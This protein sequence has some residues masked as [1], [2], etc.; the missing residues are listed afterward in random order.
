[1]RTKTRKAFLSF[2]FCFLCAST[3]IAE[4]GSR[5]WLRYAPLERVGYRFERVVADETS[6]TLGVALRELHTAWKSFTGGEISF[7][8]VTDANTALVVGTGKSK[9]VNALLPRKALNGLGRDGFLITS[10]GSH[11]VIA[12]EGDQG[13]LYG[14]FHFLRLIASGLWT[15]ET[16]RETPAYERRLLNHW[17]NLDGSIERGYAGGSLW[18]WSQLP[19]TLS[20]RYEAYA[21]AN[22]S[23]G[24]NGTVLNNV[25]ANPQILT[26]P[27]LEKVKALAEVFRPYGLQV[28]LSVN[29]SAPQTIGGLP[30]ADPL[31]KDV[32]QWW[33][34]KMKEI[35]ALIPDFGGVLVKANSEGQSGP[36]D[37]ARTHADGANML[38]DAL[39]PYRGIVI[40]R[41]FVYS[42]TQEDRAK[43][44][45]GEFVP[46]DG[47]FRDN[48]MIQIKNG[49]IDFQPREPFSPLFGALRQTPTM[50]E[51]QITQEYLG[52]SKQLVF[53]APLFEETLRSDTRAWGEGSTVARLTDATFGSRR[54]SA[55]A[56]VANTGSDANWCGHPF[57][58]AN[59]Y[60]FGRL[61]WKHDLTS[62]QIAD[63]WIRQ[64]FTHNEAFLDPVKDLMLTSRET[65]VNYM[66]PYG[67]HHIFAFRQH[68]GPEPWGD[69]PGGRAD[70]MPWYYHKADTG[71]IGFDRT[72]TGSNAVA[73]YH[74]PLAGIYA[75]PARCP[76]N[77]LLWFHRVP[78]THPLA[79]GLSLWENLCYR[80]DEGVQTVRAYQKV[81]DRLEGFVD[82]ERF[83]Q[84]Q[85]RLRTQARD[86]LVW[87]D[88][89]LLYFQTFSRRPIP[90][91]LERP[92]HDLEDLKRQISAVHGGRL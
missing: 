5:L 26:R 13:V 48:V 6:P 7:S 23:V 46:L 17:D 12:S 35:Y 4:D 83:L 60:A 29:F 81:W 32:R 39:K 59:W 33:Q 76:E 30:E 75:D 19:D 41:A 21:R 88:A 44:A 80:Y 37:Y 28:Y 3:L 20:P 84:V 47:Q 68:Y 22:A 56:G 73:Q 67:L 53:L 52:H 89:C 58:Q 62:E 87:K 51:F 50:V 36:Q 82:P 14:V 78:W 64:T 74:E 55:I 11:L 86:A 9:A 38:A 10:V 90:Y 91:E 31:N 66:M 8:G 69:I 27:Y 65:C 70:W 85:S 1:M 49:P 92:V 18:Q 16:I 63:E 45:Y 40:W 57:A 72:P 71:G 43:Q 25:N 77:L 34:K 54:L 61:A 79:N 42:P 2:F 24:I 15:G